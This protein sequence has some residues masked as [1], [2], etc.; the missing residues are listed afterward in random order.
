MA[1][2]TCTAAMPSA[3]RL[4]HWSFINATSGDTT[5]VVPGSSTAG[6]W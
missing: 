5:T 2:L 3:H 4:S 6:N 1:L